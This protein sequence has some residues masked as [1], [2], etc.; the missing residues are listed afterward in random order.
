MAPGCFRLRRRQQVCFQDSAGVERQAADG[1]FRQTVLEADHLALLGDAQAAFQASRRLRQQRCV[2]R[3]A[4]TANRATASVEQGQFNTGFLTGFDQCVLRL[5][6]RPGCRHHARIF[7]RVGIA[8]HHHLFALNKAAVPVDIQQLGHDVVGVVQVVEGLKQRGDRQGVVD[9]RFFQQKV[10]AQHVGRG[11][12][13]GDH[14][15]G[16][17]SF[18]CVHDRFTGVE[19]FAGFVAWLPVA[20]QQRALRVQ[21]ADQEGLFVGFGP[22]F[23]VADAEIAGQFAQRF[24]MTGTFLTY[25]DTHQRHAETLHAAQGVEQFAVSDD[26]HPAGLQ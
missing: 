8:N 14:I 21:L 17:R 23:I 15:G 3:R 2:C 13:H 5:I 10:N 1:H 18:R 19:H 20:R 7:R 4:A 12:R 9:S 11:L 16:H 6:L 25:V 26:A 22:A 24:G